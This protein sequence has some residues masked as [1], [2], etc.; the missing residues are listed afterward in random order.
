MADIWDTEQI[1]YPSQSIGS[2]FAPA[3]INFL[4]FK[5]LWGALK[6]SGPSYNKT[7]KLPIAYKD[8]PVLKDEKKNE[9]LFAFL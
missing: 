1:N 2:S 6:E 8:L 9:T 3:Y 4:I 7:R 5:E